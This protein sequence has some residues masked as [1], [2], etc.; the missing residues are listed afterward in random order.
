MQPLQKET[1]LFTVATAE[2]KRQ[3]SPGIVARALE[4]TQATWNTAQLA[5]SGGDLYRFFGTAI[6][7]GTPCKVIKTLTGLNWYVFSSPEMLNAI[8]LEYRH[9]QNGLFANDI[10]A[11]T[12][13]DIGSEIFK[14]KLQ[15]EDTISTSTRVNNKKYRDLVMRHLGSAMMKPHLGKIDE[16]ANQLFDEWDSTQPDFDVTE[17]CQKLVSR[18]INRF[19]LDLKDEESL[20]VAKAIVAANAYI[21]EKASGFANKEKFKPHAKVLRDAIEKALKNDTPF[22]KEL[23]ASDLTPLQKKTM[24]IVIYFTSLGGTISQMSGLLWHMAKSTE[25]QEELFK[26]T[27]TTSGQTEQKF[28]FTQKLIK[29]SFRIHPSTLTIDRPTRVPLMLTYTYDNKTQKM[30]IPEKHILT[31]YQP[32]AAEGCENPR[33]FNPNREDPVELHPFGKGVHMCVAKFFSEELIGRFTRCFTQRFTFTTNLEELPLQ[34]YFNL[35]PQS[36]VVLQ[37]TPRACS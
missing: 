21:L 28:P 8:A 12:L 22:V 7:K 36:N 29:E 27:Q 31:F 37:V 9:T 26:E 35:E 10:A 11:Q 4:A 13:I 15:P 18:I 3:Y 17:A 33:I 14:R 19:L 25:Y 6:P 2:E 23:N 5:R 24:L 1:F 30:L 16:M 20:A 32:W 34:G